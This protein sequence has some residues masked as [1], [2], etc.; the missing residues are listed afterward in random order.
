MVLPQS[1]NPISLLNLQLEYD[2]TAP[3]SL[4]EFYGQ[5]NA[6]GSGTIDLADFYGAAS[7]AAVTTNLLFELD[8]RNNSSWSG[9]GTTWY[10]TTSNSYDFTLVQLMQSILMEPMIMLRLL[11]EPG[12]RMEPVLGHVNAMLI[13]MIGLEVHLQQMND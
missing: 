10:D 8:A 11:M 5:A 3:T 7:T 1:G 6:P 12:Y 13:L 2:D 9:S 4:S